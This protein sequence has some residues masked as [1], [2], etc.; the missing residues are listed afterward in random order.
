MKTA[1]SPLLLAAAFVCS[2]G[3]VAHGAS[4]TWT[5]LNGGSW[6][7]PGNWLGGI[8]AEGSGF[9]A[10]FSTLNLPADVRITL[11]APHT[12]GSLSFDD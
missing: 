8:V 12:V 3:A 6:T 11:D 9:S 4:G 5:N 10:D 1:G 7:N 2:L